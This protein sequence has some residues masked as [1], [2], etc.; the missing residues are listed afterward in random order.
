V[1][2]AIWLWAVTTALLVA[3]HSTVVLGVLAGVEALVGPSWNVIVGSYRYALV[4][5]RLLGRVSSA[6]SLVSWGMI[7]LGSL[8]A[9]LLLQAYGTRTT[10][11]VLTAI[12]VAVAIVASSA[13]TIRDAP[14]LETVLADT[15]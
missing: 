7:P 3:V 10:F 6:G 12:F 14:R 9:G 5:D 1:I 15:R 13:R 8:A 4:P 2:G 11:L